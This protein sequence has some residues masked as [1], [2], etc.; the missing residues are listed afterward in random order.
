MPSG[1]DS[2]PPPRRE[3]LSNSRS[4]SGVALPKAS[5][6]G[7]ISSPSSSAA[8]SACVPEPATKRTWA[9]C[10]FKASASTWTGCWLG[11]DPGSRGTSRM[12]VKSCTD[13]LRRRA[14]GLAVSVAFSELPNRKSITPAWAGAAAAHKLAAASSAIPA[15]EVGR[16]GCRMA[17]CL[18]V[19]PLAVGVQR[20]SRARAAPSRAGDTRAWTTRVGMACR[21]PANRPLASKRSRKREWSIALPSFGTMPPPM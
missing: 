1:C 16:T 10:C 20:S 3:V 18:S 12:A 8:N 5:I 14:S 9:S 11:A 6:S 17:G 7:S 2:S 13:Q 21:Y 4:S 15:E 19:P